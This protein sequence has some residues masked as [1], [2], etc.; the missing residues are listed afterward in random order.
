MVPNSLHIFFLL[1][2]FILIASVTFY[3]RRE[4]SIVVK[5]MDFVLNAT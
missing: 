3:E 1:I 2:K 4:F 5:N